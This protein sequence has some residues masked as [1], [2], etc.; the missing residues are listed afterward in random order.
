M[1]QT[2]SRTVKAVMPLEMYL[3][4]SVQ[5]GLPVSVFMAAMLVLYIGIGTIATSLGWLS[6][7]Y[8][9][10]SLHADPFFVIGAAVTGLFMFQSSGSLLLY[11]F[12]VGFDDERSQFALLWGFI[13]FG[14]GGALLRLTLLQAVRLLSTVYV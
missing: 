13:G 8:P 1:A 12:L 11:Y 4:S 7:G 14:F 3:K 6:M 2:K 10:L 5:F 9:F